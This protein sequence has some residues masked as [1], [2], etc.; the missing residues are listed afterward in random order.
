MGLTT[1]S[2]PPVDPAT[3]MRTPYR[4]RLRTLS[5]HWAEY[6]F[7]AP[8]ITAFVYIAKLT[9]LYALGG[10]V[11]ATLSSHLN[12]LHPSTWFFAPIVYEKM[13]LW[14][15]LLECL[16]LAGSW[17]PL[18]A[19][20]TPMTGGWRYWARPQTI[21]IP[22]WPA[23][24]PLTRGDTRTLADAV[25]YG[26]LLG[27]LVAALA[28][29]G[30]QRD[31][32]TLVATASFA[33]VIA[34][35]VVLGLRDKVLFLAARS[36]QY[37]PL[38]V[39]FA[40]FP[41]V[42]MIVAAKLAIVAVWVCAGF[43]KFGRHFDNVIPPMLSNTPWLLSKRIKR[44]LYRDFPADL[45]P[46]RLAKR[47]AHGPG[48]FGELVPPIV[49]LLSPNR[50]VTLVSAL[51]MIGYH[52]FIMSTFPLAVPLEW[53]AMFMYATA[54]LFLG[55]PAG[56]G[57]AVTDM[58]PALLAV[59]LAGLLLFPMLGNL[60]PDLVSFLPSMRQYAGNWAS[61]MWALAPG[62]EAKLDEHIVKSAPMQKGQL[63][64]MYG[65]EA[66]E[67]VLQQA[68][69][70]RSL[71]SQGRGLNSVMINQLGADIDTYTLREAEFSCN[72][73]TGFNFG[74]GHF[75]DDSLIEAIQRRC[76]F[77]PGEFIVV[78]VES[79]AV[80]SG[81]QEYWVMDAAVGI[82]ERGSWA[83]ADAV[84]EQPW[85]PNGPIPVRVHWRLEGYSRVSHG[86]SAGLGAAAAEQ[87][88]V[89]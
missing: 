29:P 60:R 21:R 23:R 69:G 53:N 32:V 58:H 17:G 12:P 27:S 88:A 45:R 38:M 19:H 85:L 89:A 81:R 68:L 52:L 8:K 47:L 76:R 72:A 86:P 44:M 77:T 22:P 64:T 28:L 56:G 30:A 78:W 20:F 54:F 67:V 6:G 36:E 5:R 16:G 66:A 2:F 73:I 59:T 48:A 57:Y 50:T 39:F 9:V 65:A 33:P 35:L 18:A 79:E 3:F 41:F 7:G 83:V 11:V 84:E 55:Y 1:G 25:L 82:V 15:V 4:E 51:F 14:T 46:S 26:A 34:L 75:H 31:G 42:D 40:V 43:S 24:V 10:I 74:D 63:T 61:A 37:L 80:G 62:V 13:I 70:W 87:D 71:H 49:L